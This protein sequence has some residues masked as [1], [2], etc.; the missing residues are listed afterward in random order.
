M[1]NPTL[2]VSSVVSVAISLASIAAG[3]RSFGSLLILGTKAGVI[4][5]VER[6]REYSGSEEVADDFGVDSDEFA[7]AMTY[8]SQT[9]KP[10][11]LFIGFWDKKNAT[12][13]PLL[14]AINDCLDHTNW[15]GLEITENLTDAEVLSVSTLIESALVPRLFAYTTQN[16]NAL[17]ASSTTDI[18]YKLS[19][20]NLRRTLTQF[21]S[22]NKYAVGSIL[23]RI[24]SVN[25]NASNTTITLKFKNQPGIAAENLKI[26]EAKAL[27][28]KNCNVFA[29]YNNGDSIIQEGVM[30]DGTFIDELIGLDW[31]QNH[32]ELALWNL[33]KTT[34]TKIP[35]TLDGVNLQCAVLENALEQ[36]VNNGLLA[37][38]QWNGD[39]F[40][41]LE[42]GDYLDKGYYVYANS[43]DDQ[44]QY[45]RDGRNSVV[46]QIAIKLA[47][48]THF[49]DVLVSVNR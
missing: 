25:Y 34:N 29:K 26:S 41:A 44:A 20:A 36:A 43:L 38:G 24:F 46:Y 39:S 5:K 12:S 48:A 4:T 23:G 35:Q 2:P 16:V 6:I 30:C 11:Q 22:T 42:A 8:F 32:L 9:P 15:Y 10:K 1:G 33:Y 37:S 19:D 27:K 3:P 47:G 14:E 45:E 7:A 21:S 13:E 40:G 18:A 31:L 28:D 49:A 17:K